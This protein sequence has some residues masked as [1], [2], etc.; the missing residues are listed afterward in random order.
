MPDVRISDVRL[1]D[2]AGTAGEKIRGARTAGAMREAAADLVRTA[3]AGPVRVDARGLHGER[4]RALAEG[5]ALGGYRFTVSPRSAP[6]VELSGASGA[7]DADEVSRGLRAAAATAW[8]RDLANTPAATANPAWL[9]A[10]AERRLGPLG[11]RVEVHDEGWLA[12]HGFGGVLAV[13]GGSASPPRLIEATWSPRPSKRPRG[14]HVVL[15]GKGITF[16]TG[17]L[18]LKLGDNMRLMHTDMSGGAAVLG[19]LRLIAEQQLPVRVT[20]LVPAAEN[21]LSGAA[22]RPSDVITHYGGR[23]SEVGNTDAEGRLVLADALAYAAARLRPSVLV[24]IATLTGAMKVSLGLRTGGL[25]ATDDRLAAALQRAGT[26]AGEP[27]WRLPLARDYAGS[28]HSQVADATNAPGNPGAITAALFLQPFTAGL[29]WAHLDIAGPARS[30]KAAGALAK[31][32]SGFGARLL[33]RWVEARHPV[34][35]L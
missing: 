20:A 34:L 12:E 14:E 30:L 11:V 26:D 10:Q 21:A 9:G 1:V 17:G 23:T 16:D 8:A 19:A 3:G 18:N 25:F 29:P 15:V 13:G 24:D 2:P 22:M 32:A 31:G 27:L 5:L 7:D 35:A 28:L 6:S 4:L 33:A